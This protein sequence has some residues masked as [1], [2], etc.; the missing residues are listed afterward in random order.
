MSALPNDLFSSLFDPVKSGYFIVIVLTIFLIIFIMLRQKGSKM[1]Y[2]WLIVHF[3]ILSF[4]G[5]LFF[6]AINPKLNL[7]LSQSMIYDEVSLRINL[8]GI[9]WVISL[10]CLLISISLFKKKRD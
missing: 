9:T 5:Y 7:D 10:I 4:S 6:D 1:P 8:A 3:M 2:L